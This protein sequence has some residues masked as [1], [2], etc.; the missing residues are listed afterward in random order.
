[1]ATS[2]SITR[3]EALRRLALGA[4]GALAFPAIVRASEGG[5][6][7]NDRLNLA[8]IGVG[9]KGEEP[10]LGLGAQNY[11]AFCDVDPERAAKAYQQFPSVPQFKDFRV[12]FD[13]LGKQIDAVIISTPDHAHYTAGMTAM[14]L[15]KHIY[16]EKPLA[17]TIWET[18]QLHAMAKKSKVVTQ[19]G[20]QGH[21]LTGL[22]VLKEWL[23]SGVVGEI[24]EVYLWT[25]RLNLQRWSALQ[26]DAPAEPMPA[27]F[28]FELWLSGRRPRAY[29]SR[30]VPQAWRSWWD[31]GS[32]AIGDITVHMMDVVEFVLGV[33]FPSRVT[34]ESPHRGGPTVPRWSNTVYEFPARGSRP[35]VKLHWSNGHREGEVLLNKPA[36]VPHLS[37]ELIN[38]TES[39]MAFVGSRG[40]VF[41]PDMRATS[42]PQIFPVALEKEFMTHVPPATLPRPKGGHFEDWFRAIR[43][44]GK[45]GADFD[46]SAPLTEAV[47]LGTLAQ[48]T[49]RPIVWDRAKLSVLD[50]PEADAFLKPDIAPEWLI[51]V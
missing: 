17:P 20:I 6:S 50:V 26:S 40:T 11:V 33:G 12:M 24:T 43:E 51:P 16:L 22:R 42:R 34:D 27:G 30:Y 8:F 9:G 48:R 19:M 14:A 5:P 45:A 49:G 25:D 44:N 29:S 21:S 18:R 36:H 23:D 10:A 13:Q 3:R 47:L 2:S 41:M 35:A 28:P 39:G 31:F 15:G 32:G 38:A 37:T 46:Y 4:A 7:A 1:M